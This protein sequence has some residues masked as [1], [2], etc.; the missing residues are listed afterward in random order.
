MYTSHCAST[1]P[2]RP[3]PSTP[4]AFAQENTNYAQVAAALGWDPATP[5]APIPIRVENRSFVREFFNTLME[6]QVGR[7]AALYYW[8]DYCMHPAGYVLM[9]TG[10]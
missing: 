1:A 10:F 4:R 6:A 8:I 9:V 5:G 3:P 2:H 7:G